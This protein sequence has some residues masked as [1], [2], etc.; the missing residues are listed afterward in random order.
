M[1]QTDMPTLRTFTHCSP[2]AILKIGHPPRALYTTELCPQAG[3]VTCTGVYVIAQEDMDVG[4]IVNSGT[5][6]CVDSEGERIVRSQESRVDLIGMASVSLGQCHQRGGF[7]RTQGHSKMIVHPR[8]N[9]IYLIPRSAIYDHQ[10]GVAS[11]MNWGLP[12]LFRRNF[13][14]RFVRE[15]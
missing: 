1:T 10:K 8:V 13:I 12:L 14:T 9:S 3:T 6:S 15:T 7:V 2:V 11:M 4:M 5:V